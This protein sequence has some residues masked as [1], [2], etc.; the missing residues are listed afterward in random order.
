MSKQE[1][2]SD[3]DRRPIIADFTR[4]DFERFNRLTHAKNLRSVIKC[5]KWLNDYGVE[6]LRRYPQEFHCGTGMT[7]E[8][9]LHALTVH[10]DRCRAFLGRM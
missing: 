5:T 8:E 3:E 10:V 7:V 4:E 1:I 6:L 2:L 9:Y